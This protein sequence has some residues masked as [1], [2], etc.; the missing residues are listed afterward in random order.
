MS[1]SQERFPAA[2][3][4][5]SAV[6]LGNIM[7]RHRVR[8]L[9]SVLLLLPVLGAPAAAQSQ[10][11]DVKISG[12][13][14]R[15]CA[16]WQQWKEAGNGE[17]RAMALEWAQ[18]FI[19]GHNVYSRAGQDAVGTVVADS[20]VLIPLLDSYCGRNPESRMLAVFVQIVQSLGGAKVN[21]EPKA[22]VSGN[23]A[24]GGGGRTDL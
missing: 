10:S 3:L 24:R 6:H 8:F 11:K 19:A 13:G 18:G 2:A 22:P 5:G 9:L 20:K 17:A 14:V 23:P 15:K 7:R 16:E 21:L 12:M 4:Q 1:C